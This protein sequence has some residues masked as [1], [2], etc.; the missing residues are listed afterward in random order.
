MFLKRKMKII[1][2]APTVEYIFNILPGFRYG[3]DVRS[4]TKEIKVKEKST[5]EYGGDPNRQEILLARAGSQAGLTDQK[6]Q[7][8]C[9]TLHCFRSRGCKY[10]VL[11]FRFNEEQVFSS[12]LEQLCIKTVT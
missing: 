4:C 7:I 2:I 3:V 12:N 8:K 9:H 10:S 5:I 1:P 11:L 6:L